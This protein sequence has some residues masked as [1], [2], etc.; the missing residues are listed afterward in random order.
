MV[1][2]HC[3]EKLS[4]GSFLTPINSEDQEKDDINTMKASSMLRNEVIPKLVQLLDKL[5]IVPV[6]SPTL[7]SIFHQN[8]VNMRF[9]GKLANTCLLPHLKEIAIVEMVART[10][11]KVLNNHWVEFSKR[12][13][14]E[15]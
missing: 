4:P 12:E 2:E 5:T 15:E 13:F 6:D 10:S 11:K 3:P 9:L 7:S 14:R 8:G 1:T